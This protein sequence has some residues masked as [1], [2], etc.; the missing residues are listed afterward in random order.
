MSVDLKKISTESRNQNTLDID[1]V[2]TIEILK[3][4]NNEDKTIAYAVE[5]ALPSIAQVV[6]KVY[7]AFFQ[8]SHFVHS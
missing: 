3:K 5:K 2:P 1:V 8:Y 6:E 4:I 7:E